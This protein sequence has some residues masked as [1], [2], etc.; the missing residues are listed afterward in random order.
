MTGDERVRHCAQCKLNVYNISALSTKE[1]TDLIREKEG[2]LC[3][4]FYRRPDGTIITDNCPKIL[5]R[6]RD[7]IAKA[8]AAILTCSASISFMEEAYGQDDSNPITHWDIQRNYFL[9]FPAAGQHGPQIDKTSKQAKPAPAVV[10]PDSNPKMKWRNRDNYFRQYSL[11]QYARQ[12]AGQATDQIKQPK[13]QPKG[14][15]KSPQA[16]EDRPIL[17]KEA[18]LAFLAFPLIIMVLT[19]RTL[20]KQRS[21]ILYI[22]LLLATIF[23]LTGFFAI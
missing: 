15:A 6:T 19:I 4:R 12:D 18:L 21:S 1:A 8:A 22:G 3:L 5:R 20:R 7:L 16:P 23:A 9:R 11:G 14:I 13:V 2:R 10:E 17:L